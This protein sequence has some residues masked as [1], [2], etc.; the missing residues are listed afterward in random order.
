MSLRARRRGRW[1]CNVE[2]KCKTCTVSP[3]FSKT[4]R[5]F[6]L[7]KGPRPLPP[8]QEKN[9][10]RPL[11]MGA[12]HCKDYLFSVAN[13]SFSFTLVKLF[14]PTCFFDQLAVSTN[15]LFWPTC[16]FGQLA[17][18]TNLLLRPT[19]YLD[20]LAI[21]TNLLLRPACYL[22]QLA[23]KTNLLI[24]PACFFR[25]TCYLDQLAI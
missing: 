25:P 5:Y 10:V 4:P 22:D 6:P 17:I 15:L 19:C 13:I 18:E 23:I 8:F 11:Y 7:L 16:Y 21:K 14:R 20:Q 12:F 3:F 9:P 1:H 24:R 2:I